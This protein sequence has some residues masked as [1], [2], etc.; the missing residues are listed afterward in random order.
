[1]LPSA[2][3]A[4][5]RPP[6]AEPVRAAK[7]LVAIARET[8]GPPAIDS[9]QLRTMA[10][11]GIAATT[12]PKPTRLATLSIGRTD[13]LDNRRRHAARITAMHLGRIKLACRGSALPHRLVFHRLVDRN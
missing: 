3:R 2:S 12:A 7:R 6:E 5:V 13:A 4:I 9:T 11:A 1:M 8:S 10:N